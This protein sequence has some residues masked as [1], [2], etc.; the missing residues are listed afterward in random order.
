[1]ERLSVLKEAGF[2]S[3]DLLAL[4]EHLSTYLLADLS[5]EELQLKLK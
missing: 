5:G 1:M 3:E 2:E 4:L